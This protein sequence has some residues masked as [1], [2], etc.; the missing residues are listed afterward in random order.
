MVSRWLGVYV[1]CMYAEFQEEVR[2]RVL[3]GQVIRILGS[4]KPQNE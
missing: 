2:T 4:L 3:R 1:V